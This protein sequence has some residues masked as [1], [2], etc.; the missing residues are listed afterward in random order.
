VIDFDLIY[1]IHEIEGMDGIDKAVL[2]AIAMHMDMNTGRCNPGMAR[3]ARKAG[4][5]RS[6]ATEARN[7]LVK[8]GR[9]QI[10]KQSYGHAS[11]WYG[12]NLEPSGN[13][14][15]TVREQDS[16]CPGDPSQ[17]SGSRTRRTKNKQNGDSRLKN[18][19]TLNNQKRFVP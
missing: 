5:S 2:H 13:R 3:V 11:N 6:T 4:F 19:K 16:N 12:F 18:Q 8:S 15:V 1:Q 9:L 17:L 10:L 14:T 7:R